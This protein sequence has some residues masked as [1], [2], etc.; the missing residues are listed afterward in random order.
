MS[1]Y[2]PVAHSES[3]VNISAELSRSTH[4]TRKSQDTNR[5][6]PSNRRHLN[7]FQGRSVRQINPFSQFVTRLA[8]C[9]GPRNTRLKIETMFAR[10][11]QQAPPYIRSTCTYN[12]EC[13]SEG[14]IFI[15]KLNQSGPIR[16]HVISGPQNLQQRPTTAAERDFKVINFCST[17]AFKLS[18]HEV[19]CHSSVALLKAS[20]YN[21][22]PILYLERPHARDPIYF[23]QRYN[24]PSYC[25]PRR[26]LIPTQELSLIHEP[27]Q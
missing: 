11:W 14:G 6:L 12:E 1:A 7:K 2:W 17:P 13:L 24:A 27:L 9:Q 21:D 23:R 10:T 15:R 25:A 22:I 18:T 26:P 20:P 19:R 5:A 3:E 16:L 8:S 4:P